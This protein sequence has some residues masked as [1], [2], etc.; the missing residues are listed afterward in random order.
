M[1]A[2]KPKP[3]A[4]CSKNQAGEDDGAAAESGEVGLH[5][6]QDDVG[7]AVERRGESHRPDPFAEAAVRGADAAD[8]AAHCKADDGEGAVGET[9]FFL[10]HAEA[11]EVARC[12]QEGLAEL[13]DLCFGQTVE[14]HEEHGE[15]HVFFLEEGDERAA[16]FLRGCRRRSSAEHRRQTCRC[17]DR[18][19]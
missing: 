5:V 13:D 3:Y 19:G 16:E 14:K 9:Y 8:D 12:E 11:A 10:S 7:D 17:W 15:Q 4:N 18:G 6:R 2:V 1:K